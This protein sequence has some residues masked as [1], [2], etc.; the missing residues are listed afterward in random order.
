MI[1]CVHLPRFELV[2]AAGGAEKLT[3]RALAIA[4]SGSGPVRLGEVSGTAQAQ[5]VQEGMML[6]EAL[7]RC[8]TLELIPGDPVL[9]AQSWEQ[10]VRALEGIGALLELDRPGLSYFD[11]DG[12]ERI[13]GGQHGL[14]A[15]VR[16][17][18]P[19]PPRIGAGPTRFCALAAALEARSRRA[20]VIGERESRRYL[21]AQPVG[22]LRYRSQTAPLVPSFER[23]GLLTLGAIVKLGAADVADRFGHPGTL[24]RNLAL[25]HD[26]PLRVRRVEE[27]LQESMKLGESN[28]EQALQ[29]TLEVLI[30]RLLARPERRGRTIRKVTLAA[31]LVEHGTWLETVVFREA[32]TDAHRIRLALSQRL[33]L[34][35][36]PAAALRLAVEELGPP[37]GD[38]ATLLDGEHTAR[39]ARRQLAAAQ[40]RS[41]AGSNA[42]LRVLSLD[43]RSR[44]A[45]RRFMYGP[46]AR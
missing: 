9:V 2:V 19:R 22:L 41:L 4:P 14:I 31:R 3:G 39:D 38:Q 13:H 46:W 17:A 29:R 27:R 24:A 33:A 12:L 5:G 7:A 1:V 44:F 42:V 25:G 28:S 43:P 8:P 30:Q 10:T 18:L 34:L 21:A 23:L 16:D 26:T 20:R 35:P 45:D 36:A 40:V 37:G 11:S 32:L 15:A 6:S